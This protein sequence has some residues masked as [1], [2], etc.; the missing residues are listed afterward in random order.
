MTD[1]QFASLMS[2]L[3]EIKGML[4]IMATPL[5]IV[6]PSPLVDWEAQSQNMIREANRLAAESNTVQPNMQLGPVAR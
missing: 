6:T 5:Y 2:K 1:E 4:E 3:D